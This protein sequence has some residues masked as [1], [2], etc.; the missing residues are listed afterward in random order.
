MARRVDITEPTI[1]NPSDRPV[2]ED[3]QSTHR[4]IIRL[5]DLRRWESWDARDGL[6]LLHLH[7]MWGDF[8]T[9]L[10]FLQT[11][12]DVVL[13]TLALHPFVQGMLSSLAATATWES[14]RLI[15]HRRQGRK[16]RI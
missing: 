2:P 13:Q 3:S 12:A 6:R 14:G 11:A 8:A 15:I 16:V 4:E 9:G 7:A 1:E 5:S 10:A